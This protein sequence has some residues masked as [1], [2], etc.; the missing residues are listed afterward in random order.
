MYCPAGMSTK[1]IGW[2]A[3]K[4][5]RAALKEGLRQRGEHGGKGLREETVAWAERLAAGRKVTEEKA[6][7]MRAWF[8]RHKVD[9][10]KGWDDPPTPG[11]VA[12]QL[13]GGDAGRDWVEALVEQIEA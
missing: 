5:A 8:R 4:D 10:K 3:P 11:F 9:Y 13:W 6:R 2:T 7:K 1:K 12:W